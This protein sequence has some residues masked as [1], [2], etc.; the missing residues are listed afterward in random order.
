MAKR[1]FFTRLRLKPKH[2]VGAPFSFTEGDVFQPGGEVW[3]YRPELADPAFTTKVFPQWNFP[4]LSPFQ[5]GGLDFQ[6]LAIP[7]NPPQ[8]FA[9]GG[10][11]GTPMIS[12]DQYPDIEGNYY[13]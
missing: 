13:Q 10:P 1:N 3:A 11:T 12:P 8:G 2:H 5:G 9:F 4:T 7:S 6:V